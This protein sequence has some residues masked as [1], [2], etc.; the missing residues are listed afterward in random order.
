MNKE[1]RLIPNLNKPHY[2][3]IIDIE[4]KALISLIGSGN[5][6]LKRIIL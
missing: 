1:V 4:E 6:S 5:S 3:K 2:K